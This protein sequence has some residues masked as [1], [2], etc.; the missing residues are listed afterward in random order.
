MNFSRTS[1]PLSALVLIIPA[2]LFFSSCRNS[3]NAGRASGNEVSASSSER[4]DSTQSAD[5][6]EYDFDESAYDVSGGE[7]L[8][9]DSFGSLMEDYGVGQEDQA[10]ALAAAADDFDVRKLHIGND[11]H[12]YFTVA[13]GNSIDSG[14]SDTTRL[15]YWIYDEDRTTTIIFKFIDSVEVKVLKREV[16]AVRQYANVTISNSLWYDTQRAGVPPILALKLSEIY[17]WSIDFFGLQ[18]EDSFKVLYDLIMC[19]NDTLDA[20][21]IYYCDF[22]HDGKHFECF[23]YVEPQDSTGNCYWDQDGESLRKAFL[24]APLKF[25]RISSGFTYHRVHPIYH[26]VRAHTGV[27]YAAPK[28]TPVMSIGDGKV[29]SKGWGG[30]GGNTVKIRHNSVYT[31]GYMHLSRYGAGIASGSR[32]RQGQVIGY[33]GST[34]A[35]TGPHLDFRVWKN[36]SPINPLKMESPPANPIRES[37]LQAFEFLRDSLR[38]EYGHAVAMESYRKNILV[39][40]NPHINF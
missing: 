12:A 37:N 3:S 4:G 34:G 8:P 5:L 16:T 33:V 10:A 9:G 7:I 26:T 18:K 28:G 11:Y 31:T 32:V 22:F 17:A 29:I 25:S 38:S 6:N 27:D 35:S 15:A 1:Y 23:R 20:G 13:E 2:L 14:D 30:G 40:L 39:P 21:D 36:G 19:G 24:K